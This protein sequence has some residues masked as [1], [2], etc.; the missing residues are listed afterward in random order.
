MNNKGIF[1]LVKVF[2]GVLMIYLIIKA[3][4][5]AAEKKSWSFKGPVEKVWYDDKGF[6]T[7][8][9]NGNKYDLYDTK[10]DSDDIINVGDTLI[11]RKGDLRITLIRRNSN[12]TVF[13]KSR[14]DD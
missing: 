1:L 12:D 2:V 4:S 14:N 5:T 3:F 11:K 7:V 13:Y 9:V 10:W 6:P 8:W